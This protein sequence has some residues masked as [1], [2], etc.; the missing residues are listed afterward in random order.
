MQ[1]EFNGQKEEAYSLTI[2]KTHAKAIKSGEKTIEIRS[3]SNKNCEMFL[4]PKMASHKYDFLFKLLIIGESGV[5]KTCLLLRFTDDSFTANHLTT[6]GID[7]KIKIINIEGKLIKLQIWDTAGQERFR[8]ITKTY[9]KGAHGIILTY[10]VT[11]QNSFKNIRNW[12]KQIEANAQTTVRKVLVGNKCDK[13][14]RVV[15]EEE[16][17]KLADD[18]S[19][20]FFETSAKTNQNVGEVFTYLTKEILKANE[21]KTDEGRGKELSKNKAKDG[22]RGCCK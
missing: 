5:G 2:Y 20:S 9:Y 12:I 7:F 6:I 11:D 17:K 8:T 16:G 3:Y 19:M 21:G 18:Y 15:T 22:K 4:D 14:D 10:D 1:I 13:P